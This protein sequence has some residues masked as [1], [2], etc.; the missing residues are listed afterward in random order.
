[1][2]LDSAGDRPKDIRARRFAGEISPNANSAMV[3]SLQIAQAPIYR[4]TYHCSQACCRDLER[5]AEDEQSERDRSE[6]CDSD[7]EAEKHSTG[8]SSGDGFDSSGDSSGS[9][10]EGK[11][12]RQRPTKAN[13]HCDVELHVT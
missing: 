8:S 5:E 3:R 6:S 10:T 1:M 7:E 12:K 4:V 13:R 11:P 2:W 9:D